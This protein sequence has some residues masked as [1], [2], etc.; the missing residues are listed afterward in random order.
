M[1]ALELLEI[2][3]ANEKKDF[4]NADFPNETKKEV[5]SQPVAIYNICSMLGW[6][7]GGMLDKLGSDL[8]ATM[9]LFMCSNS[10]HVQ[11]HSGEL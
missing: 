10:S 11:L 4:R 2:H 5:K 6:L 9:R 3:C 7:L 8:S 1:S